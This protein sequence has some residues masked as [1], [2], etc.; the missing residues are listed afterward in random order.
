MDYRTY[1]WLMDNVELKLDHWLPKLFKSGD[2]APFYTIY[3]SQKAPTLQLF[4]HA[5]QHIYQKEELKKKLWPGFKWVANLFFRLYH[6]NQFLYY[7]VQ[8]WNVWKAHDK[9]DLEIEA[10]NVST[11][12]TEGEI[13][14]YRFKVFGDLP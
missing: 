8:L 13:S 12:L 4:R 1:H 11:D 6:T 5:L 9:I 2:L 14:F 3:F 7:F 10:D